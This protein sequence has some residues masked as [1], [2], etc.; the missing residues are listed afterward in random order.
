M[1]K[2]IKRLS[3]FLN[4]QNSLGSNNFDSSNLAGGLTL[5]GNVRIGKNNVL[6]HLEV[7][8]EVNIGSFNTINEPNTSILSKINPITIGNYC[9]LAKGVLIQEYNHPI[10]RPSTYFINKHILK[11]D[12]KRELISKGSVEIGNGVWIGA[13]SVLLSGMKVGNGA[14]IGAGSIVTKDVPPYSIVGGNPAKVIK[15]RFDNVIIEELNKLK[16]W[17][18]DEAKVLANAD[19]FN[20]SVTLDS[21]KNVR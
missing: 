17:D 18:W 13:Y 21:L 4:N 16:W 9:S 5:V 14:I 3:N 1:S 19:F 20:S 8:G 7:Y 10:N 12:H 2:L 11:T 6:K 15:Y